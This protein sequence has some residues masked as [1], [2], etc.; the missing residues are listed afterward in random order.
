MK[1]EINMEIG[2]RIRERREALGLTREQLSEAADIST[3]FLADVELGRKGVSPLTI[4]KLCNALHVS[5]DY[6]IRSRELKTDFPE[7]IELLS[8]LDAAYIPL[9]EELLRTYVKSIELKSPEK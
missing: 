8:S 6:L 2:S 9:V 5:A 3:P 4:Q 7:I 1:K